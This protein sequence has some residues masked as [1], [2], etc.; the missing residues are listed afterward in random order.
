MRRLTVDEFV[1]GRHDP[2]ARQYHV[3]QS[4]KDYY[5][6][7]SRNHLYPHLSELIELSRVLEAL[8]VSKDSIES[9][10]PQQLK[11]VDLVNGKLVYESEAIPQDDFGRVAELIQ[12]A[13]PLI[14]KLIE[15]GMHIYNF[16]E[17]HIRIEEVGIIPMYREE[18]YWFVPN[19]E[20]SQLDLFH[21]EVSLFTSANERFRTL[22]TRL[23][24][25]VAH[26]RI[27]RPLESIKLDLV[28]KYPELPHPATY[29]CETDLDFPY[30]Q[31]ML[32]IA[33][34]KLMKHLFC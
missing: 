15:E 14:R 27:M 2:E 16:V 32:P 10:L 25:S 8:L 19:L 24:G 28:R 9:H 31:T 21:Y 29:N 30:D 17:D 4:L 13:L 20:H 11:G 26:A 3:L 22:K 1:K 5:G 34:R 33:K 7:F 12:W 18:G 23:L 6:T